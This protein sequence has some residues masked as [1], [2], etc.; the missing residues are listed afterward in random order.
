[1]MTLNS[2]KLARQLVQLGVQNGSRLLVAV[3]GGA[4]SMGLLNLLLPLRQRM[5]L[6]VTAVHINHELRRE[7]PQE[8]QLVR[9]FCTLNRVPLTVRHWS[10]AAHPD[11]GIEAAARAFRYDCFASVAA[12]NHSAFVLTAHHLDDQVETV[13]FRLMRSGST[14]AAG[15]IR[16]CSHWRGRV[17]LRPLL[18]YSR[19]E[20][21][22]Y[23]RERAVPFA[24]DPSNQDVQYSRNFIRSELLPMMRRREPQV[25]RHLARFATE[26][27]GLQTLA[28]VTL[29]HFL[30]RLG[31][32][33][34]EFDWSSVQD[35]ERAVQKIVLRAAIARVFPAVTNA[36]VTQ[37]LS[38]LL[39]PDGQ[40]RS[41]QLTVR[42]IAMV[43]GTHVRI[44]TQQEAAP[45]FAPVTLRIDGV[46]M[47]HGGGVLAL[48]THPALGDRVLATLDST[49]PVTLRTRN[50]GDRITMHGGQHQK[51]R[52]TLINERVPVDKRDCLLIGV[53]QNDVLWIDDFR[54]NQLLNQPST[55]KIKA[56]LVY[57]QL[58]Q[59]GGFNDEP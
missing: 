42:L 38:A 44:G 46:G 50:A 29:R 48:V 49:Q 11:S 59:K 24:E 57:R 40:T 18:P 37:I 27:Q 14:Q 28:N 7:S 22:A 9:D 54:L 12:N 19:A 39:T 35:E 31:P 1:M 17:L 51:L 10:E 55:D 47:P 16:A 32:K 33:T 21:R 13:L 4:D 3:S 58:A 34:D 43:R 20:I 2:R 41:V 25:D 15:G 6:T 5:Q 8:E 23:V 56:N 26:M 53:R 45:Q 30:D 36:Q 52:R